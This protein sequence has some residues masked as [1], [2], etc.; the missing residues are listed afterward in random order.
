MSGN[1]P[2][3]RRAVFDHEHDDYRESFRR[4]IAAEVKPHY[5]QWETARLVPRELFSKM[6]AHGF[7]AMEV[8]EQ[9]GGQGV[10][11][12]RFNV[13]LMEEAH[14][15]DV[16]DAL[17][18]PLLHSDI[19]LPYLT[20]AGSPEQHARWLPG[21]AVG[22][23]VLAIAMTEPGTG[24]DLAGIRTRARHD[25]D[26]Y[27][28]N[29]AKTFITNGINADL[30]IVAARTSE[31]PH[32]GLSLFVVERGMS[33]FQRGR[34]IDK[35]GQ[36]ASDTAELFFND[37]RVPTDNRLGAEGTGFQQL[38]SRLVP[39]RL[40]IAV[41][42]AAGCEHALDHTLKYVRQRFA[43]GQSIGSFQSS[44]FRLAEMRTE[45]ELLRCFVDRT[46]ERY[47]AGVATPVEAAMAKCKATDLFSEVTDQCLQLHGGYGY[48][49]EYTIG[50]TWVD[51]RVMR[52]Y[53][54]A[55]E[56]M[57]ELIGKSMGL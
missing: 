25:G 51:A 15:A 13:V 24:S 31:D 35:L 56:I 7:L 33:G 41:G 32:R 19:C 37:V 22:E 46:V 8:P 20:A 17:L 5:G 29:G 54:G 10:P 45:I 40:I 26:D 44:R 52:I 42:A 2:P 6:A 1:G 12:W 38:V 3:P 55:N 16:S 21:V 39:E 4:F 11:D 47:V 23:Q 28:I 43:F 53:A 27:L 14:N 50:K 34:Q 30:V 57:K 49:T 9:Y 48:T 36:H 18:G